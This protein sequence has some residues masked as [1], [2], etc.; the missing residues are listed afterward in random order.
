MVKNWHFSKGVSPWCW[1][2]NRKFSILLF[3]LKLALKKLFFVIQDRIKAFLDYEIKKLKNWHF[4]KGLSMVL[5][6][7]KFAGNKCFLDYK[8]EELKKVEKLT[9]LERGQFMVL[10]KNQKIFHTFI[11]V[12]IGKKKCFS[13]FNIEKSFIDYKKKELKKVEQLAFLVHDFGKKN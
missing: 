2:K 13:I 7:L 8:I 12:K 4:P 5:F 6:Q 11:L 10:V 9:F 3:Q 1:S